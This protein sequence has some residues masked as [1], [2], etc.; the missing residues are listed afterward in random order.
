MFEKAKKNLK[1]VSSS[2]SSSLAAHS[3]FSS[4]GSMWSSSGVNGNDSD[5][6]WKN[7]VYVVIRLINA[8]IEET[9]VR[10]HQR[11]LPRAREAQK[12]KRDSIY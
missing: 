1:P 4:I 6:D 2:S 7:A 8:W 9:P 10:L 11:V 12:M 5:D 3:N